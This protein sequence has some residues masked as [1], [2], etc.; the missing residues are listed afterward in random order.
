MLD[1]SVLNS[2][3]LYKTET[4]K[5]P[6]LIDFRLQ[7]I[8]EILQSYHT[9]KTTNR[10]PVRDYKQLE[11][12]LDI[13]L[14]LYL[15]ESKREILRQNVLYVHILIEN[16]KWEQIHVICVKTMTWVFA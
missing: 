3:L 8:R 1:L 6:Q 15:K 14:L 4:R 16:L 5:T 9:P 10:R 12:L 7:L 2:Y 11:L 13:F